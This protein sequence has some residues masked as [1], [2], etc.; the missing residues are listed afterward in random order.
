MI[1]MRCCILVFQII[2]S[3][4]EPKHPQGTYTWGALVLPEGR[5]FDD[6]QNA[7]HKTCK[8]F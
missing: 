3:S 2:L 4:F 1:V 7:L 5:H 8:V 6:V